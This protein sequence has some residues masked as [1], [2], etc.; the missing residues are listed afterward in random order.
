MNLESNNVDMIL[1]GDVL[2]IQEV[3]FVKTREKITQ[4]PISETFWAIL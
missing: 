4:I 2:M 3:S 1:M